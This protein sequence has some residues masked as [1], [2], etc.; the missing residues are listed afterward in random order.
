MVESGMEHSA[1]ASSA[2]AADLSAALAPGMGAG[3]A[4]ASASARLAPDRDSPLLLPP[5]VP[6]TRASSAGFA[7]ASATASATDRLSSR[8]DV[9]SSSYLF[10]FVRSL[11]NIT[12]AVV[13]T[14]SGTLAA[15]PSLSRQSSITTPIPSRAPTPVIGISIPVSGHIS[16]AVSRQ[17][18]DRRDSINAAVAVPAVATMDGGSYHREGEGEGVGTILDSN[19][20]NV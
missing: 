8:G 14:S 12:T 1:S 2:T 4:A 13:N 3:S 6:T 15:V 11:S 16:V 5:S 18:S 20:N 10:E 19:L 9:D 7:T 17:N